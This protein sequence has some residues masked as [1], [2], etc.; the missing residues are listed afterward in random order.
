MQRRWLSAVVLFS[1]ILSLPAVAQTRAARPEVTL[2]ASADVVAAYNA[3][4]SLEPAQ[5]RALFSAFTNETR[6]GLWRL[7]H[8]MYL[9]DH[10]ELS[11]EQ[12]SLLTQ[13]IDNLTPE[14]YAPLSSGAVPLAQRTELDALHER[15]A[16]LFS[17]DEMNEI[18]YRLGGDRA[19]KHR[20]RLIA[21][22]NCECAGD[23]ECG[24]TTCLF[25]GC[26]IVANSCGP[27]L[28]QACTGHCSL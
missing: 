3:L 21:E 2:T 4:S 8:Q 16:Q 22:A 19:A 6:A 11:A 27:D 28:S 18:F 9:A 13:V 20:W 15:A 14:M 26:T 10:P 5:R 24:G 7:Q 25:R 17:R 12:R 1:L 23:D